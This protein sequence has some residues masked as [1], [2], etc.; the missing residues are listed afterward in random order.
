MAR[1][2]SQRTNQE[3]GNKAPIAVR[4]PNQKSDTD[5]ELAS[6]V[7]QTDGSWTKE[8]FTDGRL[9]GAALVLVAFP[10]VWVAVTWVVVQRLHF[11][12]QLNVRLLCCLVIVAPGW[13]ATVFH[14]VGLPT[15]GAG[16][17]PL[18]VGARPARSPFERPPFPLRAGRPPLPP[19]LSLPLLASPLG[20]SRDQWPG[21][22]HLWQLPVLAEGAPL[23]PLGDLDCMS[24]MTSDRVIGIASARLNDAGGALESRACRAGGHSLRS[25]RVR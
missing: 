12:H 8:K 22:P 3:S 1:A 4:M 5:G 11:K 9:S 6:A 7:D 16:R 15:D 13:G 20:H 25:K 21:F 24:N 2:R 18:P 14:E 23:L 10:P 17:F 19:P